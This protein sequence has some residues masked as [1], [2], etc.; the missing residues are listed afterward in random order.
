M[1]TVN[2]DKAREIQRNKMREAREPLFRNLDVAYM[3]AIERGMDTAEI[4]AKKQELRDVT[5]DPAI[6]AAKN[7][8]ELKAVWP[9]ILGAKP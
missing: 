3:V 9:E 8:D 5:K 6:D 4:V 1:I 2:M 7:T